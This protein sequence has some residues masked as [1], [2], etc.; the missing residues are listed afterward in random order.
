MPDRSKLFAKN[1]DLKKA[2]TIANNEKKDTLSMFDSVKKGRS[3]KCLLLV[4]LHII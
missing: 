1:E 4:K 3:D 2:L